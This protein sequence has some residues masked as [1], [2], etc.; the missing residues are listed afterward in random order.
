MCQGQRRDDGIAGTS[1][2]DQRRLVVGDA[3]GARMMD[4]KKSVNTITKLL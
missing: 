4:N 2:G 3:L 1:S